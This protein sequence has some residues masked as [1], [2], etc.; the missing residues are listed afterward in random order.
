MHPDYDSDINSNDIALLKLSKRIVLKQTSNGLGSTKA[1]KIF[2]ANVTDNTAI[3]IA[4]WG[5]TEIE[6]NGPASNRLKF[7]HYKTLSSKHCPSLRSHAEDSICVEADT[8]LNSPYF[9]DSGGPM[10][11]ETGDGEM[12]LA[13]IVSGGEVHLNMICTRISYYSKWI[14]EIIS[15]K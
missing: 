1:I 10:V 6:E 3:K 9:G 12:E 7:G 14:E 8:S 4:G 11:V 2:S 5:L 13:G 15:S